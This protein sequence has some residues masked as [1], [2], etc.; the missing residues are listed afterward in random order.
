[1]LAA[2]AALARLHARARLGRAFEK[3]TRGGPKRQ[4]KQDQ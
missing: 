2:V 4:T 3:V 1:M